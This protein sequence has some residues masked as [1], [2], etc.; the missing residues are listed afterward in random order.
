MTIKSLWMHNVL[1]VIAY[2]PVTHSL[3]SPTAW[4]AVGIRL[5]SEN[6]ALL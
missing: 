1:R 5:S 6:H 4:H 2:V 3:D